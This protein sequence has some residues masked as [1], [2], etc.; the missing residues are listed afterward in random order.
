MP[1]HPDT[2]RPEPLTPEERA[3]IGKLGSCWD[4]L[5]RIVGHGPS[6]EGDLA[7]LCAHVHALQQAVM[8]NA[9]AR[10]YPGTFRALGET[11]RG[12]PET[13]PHA[14]PFVYCPSCP[15]SPCPMGLP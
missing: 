2:L 12:R 5:T 15:V 6:R 13:C 8:S 1:L 10:M 9:A 4:D 3:V 7:E 11:L 14:D